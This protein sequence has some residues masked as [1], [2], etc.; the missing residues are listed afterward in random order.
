MKKLLS[1]AL[2]AVMLLSVAAC[3][4]NGGAGNYT[5]QNTEFFIGATGPLT[6]DTSSYGISV[7][8]GAKLAIEEI[9]AA[10]G[11]NG[12]KFKFDMK[13]DKSKAADA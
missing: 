1:V 12:V 2:S 5:A 11:L 8:E 9:N 4:N 10:G 7:Q 6:G 3:A 13:D